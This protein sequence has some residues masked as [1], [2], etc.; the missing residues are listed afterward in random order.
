MVPK[1]G[2]ANG[3]DVRTQRFRNKAALI[4]DHIENL[5]NITPVSSTRNVRVLRRMYDYVLAHLRGLKALCVGEE[6]YCSTLYLGLL[7]ALPTDLSLDYN[8][9]C[10]RGMRKRPALREHRAAIPSP[11]LQ[12][13]LCTSAC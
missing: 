13:S 2:K 9:R 3:E 5:M 4:Q 8:K 10:H 12:R 7:S 11:R 6:S 1:P